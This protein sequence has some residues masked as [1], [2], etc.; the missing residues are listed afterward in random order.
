MPEINIRELSFKY[1]KYSLSVL[2][3]LDFAGDGKSI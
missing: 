2:L 1:I 3:M